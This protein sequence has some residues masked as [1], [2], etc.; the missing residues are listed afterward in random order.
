MIAV[1]CLILVFTFQSSARLAAMYGLAVSVTMLATSLAF[2]VVATTVFMWPKRYVIPGM[3]P[4][5]LIDTLF[6][7]SGLPKFLDGA[8]VPI[9][10]SALISFVCLTWLRGRRALA[11]SLTAD[12]EPVADFIAGRKAGPP[13]KPEYAVLLTGDPSGV[14]FVRLH[15]WMPE[16]LADK[17]VVLLNLLPA[18]RP[19]IEQ[20]K[21]VVFEELAPSLHVLKASFGYMEEPALRYVVR[22]C[23]KLGVELDSENTTFFYSSP[24]LV[25]SQTGGMRGWQRGLFTWLSHVS[26]SLVDDM[27]IPPDRR[28]GL[29][30]EIQL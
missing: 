3:L 25:G 28:V 12:Q 8:W 11:R 5:L 16:F 18:A 7:T 10:V 6:V 13:A 15:H 29:G 2:Y 22:A 4:F 20:N 9:A 23:Q 24:I 1:V 14:P 19:Y 17:T 26:R 21:R 30:V 27:E